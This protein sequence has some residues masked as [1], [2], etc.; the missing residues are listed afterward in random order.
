MSSDNFYPTAYARV[1]GLLH[2]SK[3]P[4][5]TGSQQPKCLPALMES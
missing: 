5:L 4:C 2:F 3:R 1:R